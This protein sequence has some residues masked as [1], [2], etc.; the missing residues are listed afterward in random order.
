AP[1]V[2]RGRRRSRRRSPR[3][4][5]RSRPR[6]ARRRPT[7]EAVTCATPGVD[8]AGLM[9][10]LF[11]VLVLS[12]FVA[13]PAAAQ[14][15]SGA[16][17]ARAL[18][19]YEQGDEAYAAGRYQEAADAFAQAYQLSPRPLLLYNLANAY[20]RLERYTDAIQM[21]RAYLD[22]APIGEHAELQARIANL[23][24]LE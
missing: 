10:A 3:R 5:P 8:D 19:F 16:A 15:S 23:E 22:S 21:L 6:R 4:S 13:R 24:R 7:I 1:R 17:D 11:A 9:R 20:E 18:Q 14:V 2:A 12:L